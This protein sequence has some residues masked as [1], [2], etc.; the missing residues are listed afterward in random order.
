MRK[1]YLF[2]AVIVIV[3]MF[4]V[5]LAFFII[6]KAP[7]SIPRDQVTAAYLQILD[8]VGDYEKQEIETNSVSA[9]FLNDKRNSQ[10]IFVRYSEDLLVFEQVIEEYEAKDCNNRLGTNGTQ[11]SVTYHKLSCDNAAYYIYILDKERGLLFET[12]DEGKGSLENFIGE[13]VRAD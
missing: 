5:A 12:V 9:L 3:F 11:G 7:H 10:G 1:L 13:F 2:T 6:S 4:I 8:K